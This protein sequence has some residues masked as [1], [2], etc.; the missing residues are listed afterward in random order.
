MNNQSEI[1]KA[2]A[3]L[4]S[5]RILISVITI[6]L[7]AAYIAN[8]LTSLSNFI[9][10]GIP[11]INLLVSVLVAFIYLK[12]FFWS[13]KYFKY[14]KPLFSKHIDIKKQTIIIAVSA[15]AISY[16]AIYNNYAH[17]GVDATMQA[18]FMS[19]VYLFIASVVTIVFC[20]INNKSFKKYNKLTQT[21]NP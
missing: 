9:N 2:N 4:I 20:L 5:G 21:E 19:V 17:Q 16:L 11:I 3:L 7:S 10:P 14:K 15:G 18:A 13:I 8:F 12:L 6:L 1:A